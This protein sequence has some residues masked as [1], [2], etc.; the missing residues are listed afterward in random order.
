MN[1][2]IHEQNNTFV[3]WWI[4]NTEFHAIFGGAKPREQNIAEK[5]LDDIE[6]QVEQKL[7]LQE[8]THSEG[9]ADE[10]SGKDEWRRLSV[11]QNCGKLTWPMFH[12]VQALLWLT[13]F[14]N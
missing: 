3:T 9:M 4:S 1:H 8:P 7:V 14:V 12:M 10:H 5:G 13:Q 11:S 6:K 2:W